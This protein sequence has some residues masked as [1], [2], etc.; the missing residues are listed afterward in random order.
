MT[1][2]MNFMAGLLCSKAMGK[3]EML[4][5]SIALKDRMERLFKMAVDYGSIRELDKAMIY[6]NQAIKL[7]IEEKD[8]TYE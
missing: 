7:A 8:K 5:G 2:H 1:A 4:T 6:Y 3:I